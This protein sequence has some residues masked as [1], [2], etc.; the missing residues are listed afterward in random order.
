MSKQI[1]DGEAD[2][3]K[4]VKIRADAALVE[5]FDAHVERSEEYGNRAEAIRAMMKRTLG[6]ADETGAPQVPPTD[7]DQ[8]REGYMTLVAIANPDGVIPHDLAVAELSTALGRSQKV[9][10]RTVLGKLR[11][12]GYIGQ[13]TN[14]TTSNRSWKLRGVDR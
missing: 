9:V 4:Q 2:R 7:D 1:H 11:K 14:F 3:R 6:N 5:R 12:R 8:L 10:E 13:K